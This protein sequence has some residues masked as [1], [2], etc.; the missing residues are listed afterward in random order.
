VTVSIDSIVSLDRRPDDHVRVSRYGQ[1]ARF[2]VRP[3]RRRF[4]GGALL[5]GVGVGLSTFGLL[6][7]ARNAR[8]H[9]GADDLWYDWSA[10]PC[11]SYAVDHE[12]NPGCGPSMVLADACIPGYWHH[13]ADE[14]YNGAWWSLRPNEC[15]GGYWDAW[16]WIGPCGTR[17]RCHDGWVSTGFGSAK[18]ICRSVV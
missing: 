18:S 7:P 1:A 6:P 10:G 4:L 15:Y 17:Y 5:A 14:S 8:A 3:T 16:D 13:R 11:I 9:P 12:C 2:T